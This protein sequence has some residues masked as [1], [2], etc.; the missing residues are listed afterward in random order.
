MRIGI[1]CYPT[2]G[3]S[4][5]VATEVAHALAAKGHEAHLISYDRPGRLRR[6][7][8]RLRFHQVVVSA[9]PLFRYPPYDLA[10]ATRMLEVREEAKVDLFHVHYAI[11]HAVSAF[12]AR[13][14]CGG[15][16]KFVTTLHGTDIT[17][18]G[19]DR[20][21][22]RPTRFALEQSDAVTA[23]SQY[24][25]DETNLV[26]GIHKPVEV[27]PNFVDTERFKPSGAPRWHQRPDGERIL[28]HVS[29]FR[30]VKRVADVVRAF[31][32]IQRRVPAKLWLIG[33]GPDREHAMAVAA[34][35]GCQQRV[36]YHGMVD[37]LEDLLPQADLF[38]SASETESFG[39]SMLE[40]MSCGVPCVSTAVGGVAEVLGKTGKLTPFG[41]PDAM[42]AAALGLLEDAEQHSNHARASRERAVE[43]FATDRIVAQY[44]RI[45][46]RVLG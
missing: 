43:M 8:P 7:A 39:L 27:V 25:A 31:A 20:A 46:E 32:A 21:Y 41:D 17:V 38:L 14:M 18:V 16:L 10:L 22:L 5:V 9:Y 37:H 4:G 45:Y 1:V 13:S 6:G 12:L 30:P 2:V 29:N 40:A 35:L 24:L 33:D 34:D 26:F 36:E 42:A 23:V 44:E 3:G 28:V 15:E 11:P 19:S